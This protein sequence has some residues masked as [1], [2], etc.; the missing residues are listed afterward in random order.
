MPSIPDDE[1]G[2]GAHDRAGPLADG[3][4]VP[5]SEGTD[6]DGASRNTDGSGNERLS[7][8]KYSLNRWRFG[9]MFKKKKRH[10][11]SRY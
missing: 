6:D 3:R 11:S 9:G 2:A 10:H 5:H 1:D 4:E 8:S 7:N